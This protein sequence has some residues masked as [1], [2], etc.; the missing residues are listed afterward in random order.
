MLA[1]SKV[2]TSDSE[3]KGEQEH[4]RHFLHKTRFWKF[5]VLFLQNNGEKRYTKVCCKWKVVCLPPNRP[6]FVV[7]VVVFVLV[8]FTVFHKSDF[9]LVRSL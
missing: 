5:H 9:I 7:V 6:I 1:A 3:K 2:K 8:V 4:I